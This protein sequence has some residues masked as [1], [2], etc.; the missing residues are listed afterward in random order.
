MVSL[1]SDEPDFM[2][3]WLKTHPESV[4]YQT[5]Y[6]AFIENAAI[7]K[8]IDLTDYQWFTYTHL[9]KSIITISI[10]VNGQLFQHQ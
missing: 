4:P 10:T 3:L 6:N 7:L 9:Q 2:G 1:L 5:F 8:K